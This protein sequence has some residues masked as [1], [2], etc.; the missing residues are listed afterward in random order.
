M[1]NRR[2]TPAVPC[3][4]W[5][6]AGLRPCHQTHRTSKLCWISCTCS[7]PSQ[8][9]APGCRWVKL[10]TRSSLR[11]SQRRCSM[12]C[13]KHTWMVKSKIRYVPKLLALQC[14]QWCA[15]QDGKDCCHHGHPFSS[16]WSH[17]HC[18]G[19]M[20]WYI[21]EQLAAGCR[22]GNSARR[23]MLSPAPRCA[24]HPC[25]PRR[26]GTAQH[27]LHCCALC[28]HTCNSSDTYDTHMSS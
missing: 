28:H 24:H 19:C 18:A 25:R 8:L 3:P 20:W 10:N 17:Y 26:T 21:H 13:S 14:Q 12:L 27:R 23:K 5:L 22:Q 6:P 1:L 4:Q 11:S 15:G 2:H 7:W 16:A 9:A